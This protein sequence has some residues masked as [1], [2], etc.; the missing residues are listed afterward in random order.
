MLT[1]T[2]QDVSNDAYKVTID[3]NVMKFTRVSD[4]SDVKSST[5][6]DDYLNCQTYRK[7]WLS[8][9]NRRLQLGGGYIIGEST[10]L[11]YDGTI[12]DI[13]VTGLS[14]ASSTLSDASWKM[15][16]KHGRSKKVLC[17][18]DFF[19][20]LFEREGGIMIIQKRTETYTSFS[21]HK[22]TT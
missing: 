22:I 8:W 21:I 2:P 16:R 14:L 11:D 18:R 5:T 10:F 7:L 19:P 4:G 3:K 9:E 15:E 1:Q 20:F 13:L 17:K 12:D 6:P